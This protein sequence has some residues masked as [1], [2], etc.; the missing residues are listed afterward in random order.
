[1]TP[2]D[3]PRAVSLATRLAESLRRSQVRLA[4]VF[5]ISGASVATM[6][7]ATRTEADAFLKRF[8]NLANDLQDQVFRLVVATEAGR[9]PSALSRRDAA[10]YMEKLG[11]VASSDGF[12]DAIRV[13]NRLAHVYPDEPDRQAVQLNAAWSAAEVL[14]AAAATAEAWAAGRGLSQPPASP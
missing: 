6:D 4:A 2:L 10:D 13:R 11:V 3:L 1:M 9:E 14:L 8:E 7:E 12:F 5:P